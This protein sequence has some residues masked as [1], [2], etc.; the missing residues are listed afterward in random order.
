MFSEFMYW[1]LH[2]LSLWKVFVQLLIA[3]KAAL[4]VRAEEAAREGHPP[5]QHVAHELDA[6][7]TYKIFSALMNV[8][9]EGENEELGILGITLAHLVYWLQ[10][11]VLRYDAQC[12]H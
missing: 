11:F 4:A 8:T 5:Q 9:G 10:F 6:T 1:L 3:H 2:V 12:C 7:D